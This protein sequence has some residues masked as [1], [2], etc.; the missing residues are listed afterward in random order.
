MCIC[1]IKCEPSNLIESFAQIV[2]GKSGTFVLSMPW[3]NIHDAVLCDFVENFA[4]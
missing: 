2:K 1:V 4:G 3:T